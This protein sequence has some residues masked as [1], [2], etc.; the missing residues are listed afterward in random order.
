M[1][2]PIPSYE[3]DDLPLRPA[4]SRDLSKRPVGPLDTDK[5]GFVPAG[6]RESPTRK[7]LPRNVAC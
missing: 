3:R 2:V 4:C 7:P 1:H 5:L 6:Y